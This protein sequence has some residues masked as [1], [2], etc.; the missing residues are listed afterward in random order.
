MGEI[1]GRCLQSKPAAEIVTIGMSPAAIGK[2]VVGGDHEIELVEL[3]E[4]CIGYDPLKLS[5]LERSV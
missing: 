2:H 3:S 4:M 1:A 5:N